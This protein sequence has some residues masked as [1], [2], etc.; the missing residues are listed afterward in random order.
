MNMSAKLQDGNGKPFLCSD[1]KAITFFCV[2][3]FQMSIRR[4]ISGGQTCE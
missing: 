1:T 2:D 3:Y 4:P